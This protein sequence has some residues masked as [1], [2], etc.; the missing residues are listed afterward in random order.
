MCSWHIHVPYH[1]YLLCELNLLEKVIFKTPP[2]FTIFLR[3][4]SAVNVTNGAFHVLVPALPTYSELPLL[5]LSQ[6][7]SCL[8]VV[9][10]PVFP[11]TESCLSI[12]HPV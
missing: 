12:I 1:I 8:V 7:P 5:L 6:G 4:E 10:G 9:H 2:W 11:W 3:L